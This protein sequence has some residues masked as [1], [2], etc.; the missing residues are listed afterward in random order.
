MGVSRTQ[1]NNDNSDN[2]VN[3][4]KRNNNVKNNVCKTY[5]YNKVDSVAD[6]LVKKFNAPNSRNF[7]CKCAWKLSENDIWSIYEQSHK[8]SVKS[9]LKYFITV[10]SVKMRA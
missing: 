9:P 3:F 8:P 7:F 2:N 1:T 5:R 6:Y 4:L 10:C